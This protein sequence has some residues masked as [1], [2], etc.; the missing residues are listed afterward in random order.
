MVNKLNWYT[1]RALK[2]AL[3]TFIHFINK[4]RIAFDLL[5]QVPVHI[6]PSL[7]LNLT[8]RPLQSQIRMLSLLILIT[9]SHAP[10]PL[11]AFLLHRCLRYLNAP[12]L[13]QSPMLIHCQ[14]IRLT[15]RH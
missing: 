4:Q 3:F 8:P 13:K 1:F 9:T 5:V 11:P 15:Q 10:T 14:R 2:A 12:L 7:S 6:S